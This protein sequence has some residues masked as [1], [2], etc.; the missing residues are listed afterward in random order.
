M[1]ISGYRDFVIVVFRPFTIFIKGGSGVER[2]NSKVE[3]V[4][5][6]DTTGSMSPCIRL[7]R[8]HVEAA[9]TTL[10]KE[11]PELRIGLGVNGDYCDQDIY[12]T[13][14]LDLS[15]NIHS[16][17]QFVRT[18]SITNGGD[19]PECYELV[20][21]KARNLDW[22][23][24]ATKVFVLIADDVPH[25]TNDPQNRAYNGRRP[26]FRGLDWREEARAL[27]AMGVVV[28]SVQCL[29]KGS[30]AD[31]F[32]REL[33]EITGGFHLTLDQFSEVIDLIMAI[34]YKQVGSETLHAFEEKV[35]G[36]KR[37]TRAL[38]HS[39]GLLAGRER[40]TRFA[41]HLRDLEAVPPGRFQI[42]GV[43]DDVP[44]REFVEAN[45]LIFGKGQGFYEFTKTETV[46]E[47]K[48]V[49]LRDKETGDMFTGAK[50]REMIGL[51]YG[52]RGRIKPVFLD[53]YNIF[54]QSTSYNRK[55]SG[56]TRFLY[57][58]DPFH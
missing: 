52:T 23:H 26:D 10:F 41:G 53:K 54:V 58:V 17:T 56:G 39:F 16:L 34:C 4:F 28:Y 7:V 27:R 25:P 55:L 20:L 49:V 24:N 31:R 44:I 15:T 11:I 38:D 36:A 8:K 30:Y 32:Y 19:L 45:D 57:E 42:L 43:E 2:D 51:P 12:V 3:A 35:V 14:W 5:N 40:S 47:N 37:M 9:L 22:S 18:V 1:I 33:A 13:K 29:N 48:E 50:A 46:Q 21:H 6:W